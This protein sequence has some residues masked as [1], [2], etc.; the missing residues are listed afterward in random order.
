MKIGTVTEIKAHEYRVGLTPDSAKAFA[1]HGHQVYVQR[2]AGKVP[3]LR[4]SCTERQ[5]VSF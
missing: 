3:A 1:E 5:G 2:G 4:T